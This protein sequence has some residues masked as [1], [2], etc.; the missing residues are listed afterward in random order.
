MFFKFRTL[1]YSVVFAMSNNKGSKRNL[2]S[3]MSSM[4]NEDENCGKKPALDCEDEKPSENQTPKKKS[5]VQTENAGKSSVSTY[6]ES[7]SFNKL[8]VLD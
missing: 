5:K 4:E 8:L 1:G 3:W 7:K 2:P 6:F